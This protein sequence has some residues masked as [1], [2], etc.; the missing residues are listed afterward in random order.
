MRPRTP[1]L[2][3]TG[4]PWAHMRTGLLVGVVLAALIAV[5]W[6]FGGLHRTELRTL[7]LRYLM[8]FLV[9]RSG[10][11]E[12]P[13]VVVAIDERSL[14]AVGPWPW[15]YEVQAQLVRALADSGAAAV[16]LAYLLPSEAAPGE[17]GV[18]AEVLMQ[19]GNVVLA[20]AVRGADDLAPPSDLI[21]A[22]AAVG[23]ITLQ[24]DR[25]GVVRRLSSRSG[26][27]AFA[28]FALA[29][30]TG[31]GRLDPA[32]LQS[33]PLL[34]NYRP[35]ANEARIQLHRWLPTV[36]AVDVLEGVVSPLLQGKYAIVGLT[37][38][39][40]ADQ[41]NT[42]LRQQVP[43]VYV[44][45]FALRSWLLND[46][47][48]TLPG[49]VTLVAVFV[50]AMAG[51]A[52]TFLLRPWLQTLVGLCMALAAVVTG[53]VAFIRYSLWLEVTPLLA[54]VIGIYVAGLVYSQSVVDRDTRRIRQLFRRYVAPEVVDR[55]LQG[56]T[57]VEAGRR[58]EVTILFADVR[59]FTA[60]AEQASP[61]DVVRCLDKYLQVM[62]DSILAHGGMLDKYV[63]D[64]VMAVFGAPLPRPDHAQA[65]LAAA[66]D[67]RRRVA[68][69]GEHEDHPG[70]A[71]E[72]GIGIHSGEAVVGSIGSPLRREFTAIGD[73]VNV[74]SR[75][76]EA[77]GPG[78]ILISETAA[79]AAG[80]EL[81]GAA[82]EYRLR[83]R[84][85][86][87]KAFSIRE[88]TALA[89]G[90]GSSVVRASSEG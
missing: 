36:S 43:G 35:P 47:I 67:I 40:G 8:R 65:A 82:V 63:G 33:G 32:A 90:R 88:D 2:T 7:D 13:V 79:Q 53:I 42:P 56:G 76:E 71:L 16:G 84:S 64:S 9:E 51:S 89:F 70:A 22:A 10:V 38:S 31:T 66:L 59:G 44:H 60:F 57:D 50:L 5:L 49:T 74:A 29:Y 25:D 54:T 1:P 85:D 23:S 15:S 37:A 21:E 26:S 58:M 81:E 62:A 19:T 61:E 52:F 24:P 14:A 77:A 48:Y 11:Q 28:P 87:V 39:P 18:L 75:L 45:G 17:S 55:L 73:A 34:I 78:E 4:R 72:V 86:P 80:I 20:S 41:H 69:I 6:S 12:Q 27:S 46:H 3:H 30:A 68:A 83:G